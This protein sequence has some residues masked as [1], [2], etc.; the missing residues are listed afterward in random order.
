[1]RNHKL[2]HGKNGEGTGLPEERKNAVAIV[3]AKFIEML[4][5]PTRKKEV[6]QE[7]HE[8]KEGKKAFSMGA[9]AYLKA[10]QGEIS[11]I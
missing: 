5:N 4:M 9:Q 3:K 2:K 10:Y 6:T 1:M 8:I 7:L 11:Q